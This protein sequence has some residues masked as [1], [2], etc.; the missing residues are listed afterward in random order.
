MNELPRTRI[1][2]EDPLPSDLTELRAENERLFYKRKQEIGGAPDRDE[3]GALIMNG[4]EGIAR[5]I[6][7]RWIMINGPDIPML[8]L[9]VGSKDYSLPNRQYI[10]WCEE[11][12]DLDPNNEAALEVLLYYKERSVEIEEGKE[13]AE[14]LLRVNPNNAGGR[15]HNILSM[16]EN[17]EFEAAFQKCE[18]ILAEDPKNKFALRHRG[19]I[20][21]HLGNY[22]DAA[23]L[24]SEWIDSGFAPPRDFF[25]A[26][27][28]HYNAKHFSECIS[29][30]EKIAGRFKDDERILDL[31]IRAKYSLFDWVGCFELC[32][33]ILALNSRNPTGLKYLRLTR[34]RSGSG[35]TV[36]PD[37]DDPEMAFS[38]DEYLLSWFEY[39]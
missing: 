12:L 34:V 31:L 6:V 10:D 18:E 22:D 33:E 26:A 19:I 27:R 15:R 11:L 9:L 30:L 4:Y 35:M 14:K 17:G 32:E 21:T 39:L 13:I 24:W 37:N 25:R 2:L 29:L 36:I 28:A 16:V 1:D 23:F 7:Q 5:Y 38:E 20:G 8:E 3:I